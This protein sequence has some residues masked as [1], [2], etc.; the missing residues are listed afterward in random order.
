MI[1][2]YPSCIYSSFA[3][4]TNFI[5]IDFIFIL[6]FPKNKMYIINVYYF[7]NILLDEEDSYDL[8]IP[9]KVCQSDI[10]LFISFIRFIY[11]ILINIVLF[12]CF[13]IIFIMSIPLIMIIIIYLPIEYMG[14]L[15]DNW[16]YREV[17]PTQYPQ[18]EPPQHIQIVV[19]T[20]TT[21]ESSLGD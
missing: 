5:K 18:N 7:V 20:N 12:I 21:P 16:Y 10:P 13:G 2:L 14:E 4:N 19:Q 17:I 6:F 3:F 1:L 9:I 15:F 11:A 8:F